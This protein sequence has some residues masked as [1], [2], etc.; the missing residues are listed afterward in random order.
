MNQNTTLLI[1]SLLSVIPVFILFDL[2]STWSVDR[3]QLAA[4]D[5]ANMLAATMSRATRVE[6]DA[7]SYM[8]VDD[9]APSSIPAVEVEEVNLMNTII[10]EARDLPSVFDRVSLPVDVEVSRDRVVFTASDTA[11]VFGDM[12]HLIDANGAVIVTLDG[13]EEVE[14]LDPTMLDAPNG[15]VAYVVEDGLLC[16]EHGA[17]FDTGTDDGAYP[18]IRGNPGSSDLPMLEYCGHVEDGRTHGHGFC[19]SCG[20]YVDAVHGY[21]DS[22][23]VGHLFRCDSCDDHGVYVDGFGYSFT[24]SFED[25]P[26]SYNVEVYGVDI[27]YRT[28]QIRY[29]RVD[30]VMSDAPRRFGYTRTFVTFLDLDPS[31]GTVLIVTDSWNTATDMADEAFEE[32]LDAFLSTYI[33]DATEEDAVAEEV[34]DIR[35]DH[36]ASIMVIEVPT[37]QVWFTSKR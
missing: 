14:V 18:I 3:C 10:C 36:R 7:V 15:V 25:I 6:V 31:A 37:D 16:P 20:S 26:D 29:T 9:T 30:R 12:V 28:D 27:M 1:I 11:P 33:P 34:E 19:T 35:S 13:S 32:N 8:A 17:V 24:S 2:L 4:T 21:A 22:S 23:T 5:T